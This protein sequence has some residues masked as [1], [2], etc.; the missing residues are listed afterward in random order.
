MQPTMSCAVG[1]PTLR[2]ALESGRI[3]PLRPGEYLLAFVWRMSC[4]NGLLIDACPRVAASVF[5]S[6]AR[7]MSVV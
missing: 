2:A 5:P 1:Q 7:T 4:A 6:V 3:Q